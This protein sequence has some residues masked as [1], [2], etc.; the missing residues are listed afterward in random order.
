ALRQFKQAA[1]LMPNNAGVLGA[2]GYIHRR[3]GKLHEA[4]REFRQAETLDPRNPGR[5]FDVA[6]TLAMLRHYPQALKQLNRA[7]A[8]EPYNFL[9]LTYKV[10]I[11]LLAGQPDSARKTA[12]NLPSGS[13]PYGQI[14]SARFETAWFTH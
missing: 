14:S 8:I 4:L 3:Q 5:P 12:A 6:C 1:A 7:L 13:D 11:E 10:W 9:A 2:I